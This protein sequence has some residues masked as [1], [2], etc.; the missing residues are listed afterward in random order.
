MS[1]PTALTAEAEADLEE[2]AGWYERRRAG[3]GRD[4]V[5]RVHEMLAR[6]ADFPDLYPEVHTGVRRAPLR[7][8][9]YGIFYRA[10]KT[11]LK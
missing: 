5:A 9:P 3:L 10:M 7:R 1:L 6:V 8:F 2:A 4:L 11:A